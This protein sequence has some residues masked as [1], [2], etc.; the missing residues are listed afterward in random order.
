M[1]SMRS[2]S[3]RKRNGDDRAASSVADAADAMKAK[4]PGNL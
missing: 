1:F 4:P 3:S 2:T